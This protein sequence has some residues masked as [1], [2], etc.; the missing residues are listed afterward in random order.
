MGRAC[1]SEDKRSKA[2]LWSA[3]Q[4]AHGI[5]TFGGA[6]LKSVAV[7]R[8]NVKLIDSDQRG[9]SSTPTSPGSDIIVH[10]NPENLFCIFLVRVLC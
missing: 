9:R 7:T 10:S 5:G 6:P 4:F 1:D 2:F 3:G 8:F